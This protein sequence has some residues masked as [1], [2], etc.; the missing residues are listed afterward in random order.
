M[1]G[2]RTPRHG[3]G[4]PRIPWVVLLDVATTPPAA[5]AVRPAL[6]G[7]AHDAGWPAPGD[8]A[9]LTGDRRELLRLLAAGGSDPL[10]L[11]VHDHG[12]VVPGRP[13]APA[14]LPLPTAAGRPLGH[15]LRSPA[16][17][18]GPDRTTPTTRALLTRAWEVAARPPARVAG[19]GHGPGGADAFARAEV[20]GSPRTPDLVHAG[21]Q[22]LQA[23]N[24]A[25]HVPARRVSVAVGVST[26]GGSSTA[27]ADHSGFVRL[28]DVERMDLDQIRQRLAA[29]PLQPGGGGSAGPGLVGRL[30]GPAVRLAAPRLGSTLLV[31]HLGSV[32]APED[33]GDLAF[34]PVTGGG[35]GLSLGAASL[36]GRTTLTLR[37]RGAAHD[38]EGLQGLLALVVER[39]G[40]FA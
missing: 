8:D 17:G 31:S 13:D 9:V 29:A 15:E 12:V 1:N 37:A 19:S 23:W 34:H 25:R 24:T 28:R 38:D 22:A 39:L 14:G 27:L 3:L 11:G 10:R 7:L 18:G 33:V 26:V 36:H 40:Y 35:S 16:R 32:S 2:T 4:D 5:A 20:A 21:A 30:A 6:A